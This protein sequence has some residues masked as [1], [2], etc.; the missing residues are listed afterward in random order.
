MNSNS[1]KV[2]RSL[3]DFIKNKIPKI[4]NN[5]NL[6]KENEVFPVHN[7]YPKVFAIVL[8]IGFLFMFFVKVPKKEKGPNFYIESTHQPSCLK[9][10]KINVTVINISKSGNAFDQAYLTI[11]WFDGQYLIEREKV[12]IG[13]VFIPKKREYIALSTD[14]PP[15]ATS[16]E[17]YIEDYVPVKTY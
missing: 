5:G 6:N 8:L 3:C 13:G 14:P 10:D 15:G 2:S 4:L 12:F 1:S 11:D 7:S 17:F 16:C 9:P